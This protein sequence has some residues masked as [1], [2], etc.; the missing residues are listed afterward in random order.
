MR[1]IFFF[2][3]FPLH[4]Y[5]I[6]LFI[7]S[8]K[9]F[10]LFFAAFV[11]CTLI[12]MMHLIT[13]EKEPN[14][15]LFFD[16]LLQKYITNDKS[17]CFEFPCLQTHLGRRVELCKHAEYEVKLYFECKTI[18][19]KRCKIIVSRQNKAKK[20]STIRSSTEIRMQFSNIVN[21][22]FHCWCSFFCV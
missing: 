12:V 11:W 8:C 3:C 13:I 21:S 19:G 9:F 4:L 6:N 16:N 15:V 10:F 22:W 18:S 1:Q 14:V 20:M 2:F 7:K 5:F 17:N